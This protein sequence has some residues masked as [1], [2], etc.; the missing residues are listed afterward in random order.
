VAQS[1][2]LEF[3]QK[4]LLNIIFS[5]GEYVTRNL[6]ISMEFLRFHRI[7]RN[8]ALDGD[9]GTNTAYFDGVSA[10]VHVGIRDFTMKYMTATQ[11]LTGGIVK[12]LS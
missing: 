2:A 3:L 5:G 6:P 12:I 1:K 7:L 4:R 8:S 9:K 10:T 11:A